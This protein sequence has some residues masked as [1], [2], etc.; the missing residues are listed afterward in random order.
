MQTLISTK[1]AAAM[2]GVSPLTLEV[3]KARKYIPFIRLGRRTLYDPH[4]L[5]AWV[6]KNKVQARSRRGNGDEQ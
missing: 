2:L 1:E 5:A 6:E 4:D 3:W